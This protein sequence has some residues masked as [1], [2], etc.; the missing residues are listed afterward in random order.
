MAGQSGGIAECRAVLQEVSGLFWGMVRCVLW[1]I[2]MVI[3]QG[4]YMVEWP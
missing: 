4:K 2:D 3:H 1:S